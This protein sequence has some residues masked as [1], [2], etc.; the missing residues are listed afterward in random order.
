VSLLCDYILHFI[1]T[2]FVLSSALD[3]PVNFKRGSGMK[4][5]RRSFD[6]DTHPT[7]R[8][9][10]HPPVQFV[11]FDSAQWE[12]PPETQF[13]HLC[14]QLDDQ[15][16]MPYH[17]CAEQAKSCPIGRQLVR[18]IGNEIY[19]CATRGIVKPV[20]S[21]ATMC[22]DGFAKLV[23]AAATQGDQNPRTNILGSQSCRAHNRAEPIG[24]SAWSVSR[25]YID[26]RSHRKC[27]D[28][29]EYIRE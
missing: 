3:S 11:P 5:L 26:P 27:A 20:V 15:V 29:A 13:S 10:Y 14:Q 16:V 7:L 8:R 24:E 19:M 21:A 1:P 6:L 12:F 28:R 22:N 17:V 18:S 2:K 23:V 25:F 9:V 4:C